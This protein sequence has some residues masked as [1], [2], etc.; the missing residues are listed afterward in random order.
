MRLCDKQA[1][2]GE[3]VNGGREW[4]VE[5]CNHVIESY[6][7]DRFIGDIEATR[8]FWRDGEH[9]VS[10]ILDH[11]AGIGFRELFI[12]TSLNLKTAAQLRELL[13]CKPPGGL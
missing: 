12:D 7:L 9:L 3:G 11:C 10:D 13:K 6:G 4:S 1:R 8:Q 5:Q 2:S